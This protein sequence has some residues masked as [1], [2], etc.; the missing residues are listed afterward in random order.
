MYENLNAQRFS[1]VQ[2]HKKFFVFR[3]FGFLDFFIFFMII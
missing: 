3:I 2:K 1:G